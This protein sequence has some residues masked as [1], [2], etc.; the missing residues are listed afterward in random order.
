[1]PD[2]KKRAAPTANRK[3]ALSKDHSQLKYIAAYLVV[4]AG[5]PVLAFVI[6]LALAGVAR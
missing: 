3:A 4:A 1:M 5:A 2:Q 6:A